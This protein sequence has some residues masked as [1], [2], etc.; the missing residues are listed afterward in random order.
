M[1]DKFRKFLGTSETLDANPQA[2]VLA[3]KKLRKNT[4]PLHPERSSTR[5]KRRDRS[6]SSSTSSTSSDNSHR[7]STLSENTGDEPIRHRSSRS[8]RTED[9]LVEV[10]G[11]HKGCNLVVMNALRPTNHFGKALLSYR[12]YRLKNCSLTRKLRGTSKVSD[13]IEQMALSLRVTYFG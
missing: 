7:H 8:R 11:G 3:M 9:T 4:R 13:C 6:Q 12:Y 10:C 1:D 5:S 2:D